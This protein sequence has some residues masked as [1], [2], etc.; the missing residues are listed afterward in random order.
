MLTLNIKI[1]KLMKDSY[2]YLLNYKSRWNKGFKIIEN[3]KI[4]IVYKKLF[5]KLIFKIKKMSYC[6][7]LFMEW[8]CKTIIIK[9]NK[10]KIK[11]QK[12]YSLPA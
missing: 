3:K 4:S 7:N 10:F 9:H 8:T 5:L 2:I 6:R 11:T 1:S 12:K